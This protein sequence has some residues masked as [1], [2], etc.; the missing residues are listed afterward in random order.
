[1]IAGDVVGAVVIVGRRPGRRVHRGPSA[2]R[3]AGRRALFGLVS[4]VALL[5][6][7]MSAL[8]MMLRPAGV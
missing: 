4:D 2:P 1:M 3:M 6:A 8:S 7:Y 5:E